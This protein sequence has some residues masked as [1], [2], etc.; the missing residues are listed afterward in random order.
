MSDDRAMV[1][2]PNRALDRATLERVLARAAELQA[3]QDDT[4]DRPFSEEQLLQAGREAGLSPQHLRQA[5]AEERSRPAPI[6]AQGNTVERVFGPTHVS[7]RR[8]VRGAPRALL[9]DLDCWMY[10]VEYL[11]ATRRLPERILWEARSGLL[12]LARRALGGGGL[13][14]ARAREVAATVVPVDARHSLV[15]L[16]ADLGAVRARHLAAGT[17]VA[18]GG[19]AAGGA[20][21]ALHVLAPIALIPTAV[22]LGWGYRASRAHRAMAA[23]T[24]LAL[25][26]VLDALERGEMAYHGYRRPPRSVLVSVAARLLHH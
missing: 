14:L 8:V 17:A 7:A 18:G 26:Q 5:L 6:V 16:D 10:D 21:I 2:S 3:A 15:Q 1:P 23:R 13:H 19:V 24:Q 22:G 20:L 4:G 11:A 9:G 25:E 12:T